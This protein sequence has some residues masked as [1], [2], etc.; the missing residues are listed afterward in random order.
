MPEA[1]AVQPLAHAKLL[2]KPASVPV[3]GTVALWLARLAQRLRG[4]RRYDA[5]RLEQVGNLRLLVIPSV[6][7][8]KLLRTGAY[9][10]A[11]L[12]SDVLRPEMTVLDMGT[13]SGV[14][15]LTA[16]GRV[17]QVIAVD[18]NPAAVRCARINAA[19]NALEERV[20]V[21]H[22]DL[23]AP[24]PGER[25][26]L[27]LFN[28]PFKHGVPRSD[29]DRAWRAHDVAG[30]F[31]AGLG[32]QL[33]PGGSALVLLSSYGD[34]AAF[35]HE[36]DVHGFRVAPFATRTFPGERVTIFRV[37]LP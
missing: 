14:C 37:T 4:A 15:A 17:R 7:N 22:G 27:V 2:E 25:F 12:N 28:P 26:D 20:E 16:A 3:L 13:G 32:A 36:L 6:F 31:A 11:Q 21:R 19:V 5:Y 24:V 18:I 8:P 23:F 33:A 35:L 30:R 10:A 29:R 1:A 9:F 34:C